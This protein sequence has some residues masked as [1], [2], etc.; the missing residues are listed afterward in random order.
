MPSS[1]KASIAGLAGSLI[2]S[3]FFLVFQASSVL[4]ELDVIT[5]IDRLGSIGRAG[6]WADHFIVGVLLWGPFFAAFDATTSERPRW[7]KGLMFG[8]FAWLAM[9]L[10]FMPVVGA[11]LFGFRSGVVVPVG[12]LFL[13]I[14]YGAV[15][16]IVFQILDERFPTK[17]LLPGEQHPLGGLQ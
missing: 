11:G 15:L 12:M 8:I 7:Q 14:I 5:L 16:G 17:P 13:H 6:A 1:W 3:A 2:L 10:I 4:V 9:M